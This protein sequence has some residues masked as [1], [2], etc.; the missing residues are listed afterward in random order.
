[1]GGRSPR[2]EEFP[3]TTAGLR[4]LWPPGKGWKLSYPQLPTSNTFEIIIIALG[5]CGLHHGHSVESQMV[6]SVFI[7]YSCFIILC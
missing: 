6:E 3:V 2:H 1:M 4:A 7:Q 5:R